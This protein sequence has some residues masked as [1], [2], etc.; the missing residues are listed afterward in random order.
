MK[1]VVH[2]TL[3]KLLLSKWILNHTKS[4]NFVRSFGLFKVIRIALRFKRT[5]DRTLMHYLSLIS[6]FL[7]SL[8]NL[9][10]CP[11]IYLKWCL[12]SRTKAYP[13]FFLS[14]SLFPLNFL[15]EIT[16]CS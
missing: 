7:L 4:K 15:F 5:K 2:R 16:S 11:P 8:F 1:Y 10:S 6:I 9:F 13:S 3:E 12:W 14:S